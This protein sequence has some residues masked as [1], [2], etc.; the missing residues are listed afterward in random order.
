MSRNVVLGT[1][2]AAILAVV[3]VSVFWSTSDPAK[4]P[5]KAVP[6]Q[7]QAAQEAPLPKPP[8]S[9]VH[10][11]SPA[12]TPSS[13]P[14]TVD[15]DA[16]LLAR[17]RAVQETDPEFA[18]ALAREGNLRFPDS[19]DAPE[20]TSILIHALSA[21]GRWPE[22]RGVAEDMV[23]R[24]PDSNWVREIEGFTGAHRHRNAHLGADGGLE[25]D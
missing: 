16:S 13:T 22:G 14:P 2:A 19:P 21:V 20:R 17:L 25:F 11:P 4:R 9:V 15:D 10:V 7:E 6:V 12:P 23:N 5:A 1:L 8:P 18:I 3:G 24:Y